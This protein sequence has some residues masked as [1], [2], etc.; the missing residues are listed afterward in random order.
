MDLLQSTLTCAFAR[1]SPALGDN[2]PVGWFTVLV[3]LVAGL[4][5]ARAA[6]G[7]GREGPQ[8]RERR[9]WWIAA[10]ILLLLAVNKQLDLQSLL[11][12]TAR[13]HAQLA[14]WYGKHRELQRVFI[15]LVIGGGIGV[16]GL[17]A[18]MLRGILARIW[19]ALLGLC[20]VCGF[21][22]IRAAS[23]HHMDDLIGST[24]LGLRMNWILELPGPLLVLAAA[25]HRRRTANPA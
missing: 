8:G 19:P 3:Y 23:F 1:W 12:M 2:H 22:V 7:S 6:L 16:L 18:L 5:S 17:L 10:V 13:C 21:V 11:T 9:F 14:G 4:A 15:W 20:F 25:W 24:M